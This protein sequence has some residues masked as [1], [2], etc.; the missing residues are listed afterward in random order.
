VPNQVI[1]LGQEGYPENLM[2]LPDPPEG[3]HIVGSVEPRD[4]LSVAIVGTRY[5]TDVGTWV[6]RE[7]AGDVAEAGVTVVSGLARGIDG[8]AHRAA[9]RAGGRTIACLG[10]GVD[11]VYPAENRD[12]YAEIPSHGA[13]LSEYPDGTQPLPYRFPRRNRLIAGLSLGVVVIEAGE[14]SGALNT[15]SWALHYGIPVMAVPGSARSP[16]SQGTNKLIQEGAY[17][18]TSARDVLSFLGRETECFPV[19]GVPAKVPPGR[20]HTLEEAAV[21]HELQGYPLSA[22][23]LSERLPKMPAGKIAALLVSLEMKGAVMRTSGGKLL[24]LA[25]QPTIG[26]ERG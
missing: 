12:L 20:E 26:K 13:I 25:G 16:K 4:R 9:M 5:P 21:L 2:R 22:D 18:V 23:A 14:R 6:A 7:I 17:L 11:V 8:V 19:S 3:L 1:A 10:C 15:A 24:A